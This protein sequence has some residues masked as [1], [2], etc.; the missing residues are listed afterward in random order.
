MA[1]RARAITAATADAA[2]QSLEEQ[3]DD[4]GTEE[5]QKRALNGLFKFDQTEQTKAAQAEFEK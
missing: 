3:I 2:R 5:R 1:L 4:M